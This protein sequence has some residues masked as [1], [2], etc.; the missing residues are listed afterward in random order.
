MNKNIVSNIKRETKRKIKNI[1]NIAVI[2]MDRIFEKV[3]ILVT[4]VA[5]INMAVPQIALAGNFDLPHGKNRLPFENERREFLT[6]HPEDV[7]KL[8]TLTAEKAP[9]YSMRVT[10]TA[11]NSEA[12][13]TDSTPCI[14]ASGLDICKRF[15]ESI[16]E[17]NIGDIV[18]TNFMNLPFGTKIRFPELYPGKTFTVQDRMNPRYQ[19]KFDIWMNDRDVA[20][21][22]GR[23]TT[24]VE[25]F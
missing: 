24:K 13:Q 21:N 25:I 11:Y 18:A 12:G 5:L 22:F 4:L 16:D 14:T 3:L 23:K 1:T 9:R 10:V 17:S 15:N 2:L 6:K 19:K 8:P 7:F 20:V